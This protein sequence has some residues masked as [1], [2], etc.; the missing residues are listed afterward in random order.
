MPWKELAAGTSVAPFDFKGV[1]DTLFYPA[2]YIDRPTHTRYEGAA[3]VKSMT[4]S[5]S[6]TAL[7]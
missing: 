4:T 3:G 6:S 1:S 7:L 5:S 2:S